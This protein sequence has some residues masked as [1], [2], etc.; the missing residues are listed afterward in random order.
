M[1]LKLMRSVKVRRLERTRVL[2]MATNSGES[3]SRRQKRSWRRPRHA[4]GYPDSSSAASGSDISA[5][6]SGKETSQQP[7][8]PLGPE[9][10]TEK[11]GGV[12]D[13]QSTPRNG[14]EGAIVEI[15]GSMMEG[16]RHCCTS[17]LWCMCVFECRVVRY[18]AMQLPWVASW[19]D[20]YVCGI[21]GQVAA[22]LA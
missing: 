17:V 15:D 5:S 11:Q 18:C 20:R 13:D 7:L 6:P 9:S 22:S 19:V 10:T 16:V 12:Q 14:G 4:A 3:G 21:S 8:G 2:V 1:N